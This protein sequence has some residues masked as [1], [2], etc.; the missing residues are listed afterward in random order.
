MSASEVVRA[1]YAA[2]NRRD[3][4]GA[5][6]FIDENCVYQDFNFPQPFEGK[7]A[8]RSLFEE[9]C[10]NVPPTLTFVIDDITAGDPLAVGMTWHV[11]LDGIAFPNG[12]GAS[13][14][15]LSE[16]SGKVIFARDI[17]EPPVK[18]GKVAFAIIRLVSPLV[19]RVLGR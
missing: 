14:Y 11:E 7:A 6:A 9:S 12:R 10:N 19:R 8:V 4:E 17:V 1:M 13:F 15:R 5:I 3:V 18:P 16:R 2:I